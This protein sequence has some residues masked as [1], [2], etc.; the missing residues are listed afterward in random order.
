MGQPAQYDLISDKA[1]I[2]LFF[3]RYEGLIDSS[4]VSSIAV[5]FQSNSAIEEYAGL[6]SAPQMREWI[7]GRLVKSLSEYS[8]SVRNK[9]WEATLGVFR[10]DLQR[11]KTGQL[12]IKIAEM[13][14][15]AAG[16]DEKKLSEFIDVADGSTLGTSY[17]G[18][19]FFDTDHSIGDSGTINNDI[20]VD[21][22]ALPIGDVTGMH[23]STTAPSVGEAALVIQAGVQQMFGFKNDI[24]EPANHTMKQVMI[25]VPYTLM[26]AF[27]G[28]LSL[29][30]FAN[31]TSNPLM[32]STIGKSLV[33]NPRL[34]WTDRIAIFRTD[35][36]NKP[37]LTQSEEGLVMETL[38]EGTEEAFKTGKH[39]YG[40]RKRCGY[41]YFDFTK[42]CLVTMT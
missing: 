30:T 33:V 6:G 9:D 3:S 24:G 42:A 5:N 11:D 10:K 39:L 36:A 37:L 1:V 14:E 15:S 21:I 38:G 40:L 35:S 2:G 41:S 7:G 17:D 4:W 18:Q 28:A 8:M 31:G 23:G 34:T 26:N 20:T 12:L 22:S 29:A 27:E 25:M 32:A 19:Y 13:A 16:H